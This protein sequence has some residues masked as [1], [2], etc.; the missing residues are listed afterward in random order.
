MSKQLDEALGKL[1]TPLYD[2][3]GQ[4]SDL[5]AGP[6]PGCPDCTKDW[7]CRECNTTDIVSLIHETTLDTIEAHQQALCRA[8]KEVMG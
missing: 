3:R 8:V 2:G 5:D 7:P 4:M 1:I 6:C